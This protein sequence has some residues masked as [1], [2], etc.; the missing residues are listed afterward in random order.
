[1][2]KIFICIERGESMKKWIGIGAIVFLAGALIFAGSFAALGWDV[3][4]LDKNPTFEKKEMTIKNNGQNIVI[5]DKNISFI[6]AKSP[7][8]EIHFEYYENQKENYKISKDGDIAFTKQIHYKWYD[9]IFN[10]DMP[11]FKILMPENF[12]GGIE[13]NTSNASIKA[14]NI[15]AQNITFNTS[16]GSLNLYDINTDKLSAKTNNASI[17]LSDIKVKNMCMLA[18]S[19]GKITANAISAGELSA[20]TDNSAIE[21]ISAFINGSVYMET[22]NGSINIEQLSAKTGITLKTSN[23]SISGSIKGSMSDFTI[24]SKTSNGSNNLPDGAAMGEQKLNVK[25]SNG[26]I[27]IDFI[28]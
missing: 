25:T 5:N 10:F 18:T 16:N 23:S 14:E 17:K 1:M 13:I 19:N 7:D 11:K 22:S 8:A 9:Y 12:A 28:K 21:V 24:S 27:K 6:I 20:Q 26:N 3:S 15:T 2:G 4:K